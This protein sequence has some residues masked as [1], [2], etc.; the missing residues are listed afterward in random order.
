[1]R[2]SGILLPVFSLPSD[3]GIGC[4]SKEAFEFIRD[5]E[6]VIPGSTKVECGNYLEHDL[7]GAKRSA[8]EI[9]SVLEGWNND[10]LRYE[11][12]GAV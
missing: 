9:L 8:E 3:Y 4:L 6:G 1:M 12:H 5:F 2:A 11:Y 10:M 7:E